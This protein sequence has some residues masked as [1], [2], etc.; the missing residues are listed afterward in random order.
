[1]ANI[2]VIGAGVAGLSAGI[3]ARLSG[4]E[5][6]VC[7]AHSIPGGNLTGWQRGEYHIDNCIHWL[8][9][10]N[11]SDPFYRM[12]C[13]LGVLGNVNV[14]NGERLYSYELDGQS[15]SLWRDLDRVKREMLAISP[16]D[17]KEILSFIRGVEIV[18]RLNNV[19]GEKHNEGISLRKLITGA[20]LL[21][22]YY[23]LSCGELAKR[24]KSPLIR[25]FISSI[26][27]KEFG[28]LALLMIFATFCSDNGGIP[29]GG[30]YAMAGRMSKRLTDLGGRLL[31]RKRATRINHK[32]GRV[33]SVE[34][35]DGDRLS[36][37]Y[38][39]V[40]ADPATVFGSMTYLPMPKDL[41]KNYDNERLF[42]FS[43]YHCAFACDTDKLP[44][45]GDVLFRVPIKYYSKLK[46][47][48]IT[49]RE[50]SHE[51]SYAPQGKTVLQ[52][53]TYVSEEDCFEFIKLRQTDIEAYKE[54]KRELSEIIE[55][56]I[57]L[58]YPELEGKI[59]LIDVWTPASYKRFTYSDM[60]AF[61]S[62]ALPGRK[63]PI[64]TAHK[65]SGA[66]NLLLATQWQRIPGGLPT[67]AS[68]GKTAV[69]AIDRLEKRKK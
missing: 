5:V 56:C 8:T 35:E 29:E 45:E 30:S 7:E 54:K 61:M 25:L 36:A 31:T 22:K 47:D 46:T 57:L 23:C 58:H 32:A 59:H 43:A 9:G 17:E 34:F 62:F 38:V 55:R 24:F 6:T 39:I 12:W 41:R 51:A 4:H 33:E 64:P 20:P 1:M 68:F 42:R 63:L 16:E 53:M 49:L 52:T 69:E 50:F 21:V 48:H 2:L 3:Y 37:D 67:A 15:I 13:D 65:V 28:S 11:P 14:H 44:F 10:T 60:G 18:E 27:G 26:I 40:T 66:Q 19:G